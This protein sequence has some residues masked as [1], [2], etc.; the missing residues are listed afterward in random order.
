M[1]PH[2]AD[3]KT[4]WER[5]SSQAA[6]GW[7]WN[8]DLQLWVLCEWSREGSWVVCDLLRQGLPWGWLRRLCGRVAS[9]FPARAL[10]HMPADTQLGSPGDPF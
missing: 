9:L 7:I 8:L 1:C 5:L 2:F 3:E 6:K 4:G 10:P